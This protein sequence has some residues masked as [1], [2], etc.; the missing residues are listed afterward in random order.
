MSELV[1]TLK[2]LAAAFADL[3]GARWYLFG[4]Q[5]AILH[6]AARATAD[7]D[8]TVDLAGNPAGALA[9]ALTA[10]GFVLRFADDAFVER[11]RVIPATHASGVPVDVVIAG[12]G[13]EEIFFERVVFRV[14][15]GSR[16]PVASAEDVIEMKVL[17]GRPKDLDDVRAIA[18]AKADA[19]DLAVIRETLGLLEGALDQSDLL[20]AF[21]Q[22]VTSR[23]KA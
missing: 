10:N 23:R 7:I 2:A 21:E 3:D 19:L 18:S 9:K 12:P 8:V 14:I 20:P 13:L 11:T 16:V 17:A 5:A 6:G 22:L 1:D 15:G 4:A